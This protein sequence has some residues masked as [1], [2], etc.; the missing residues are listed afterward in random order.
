[1]QLIVIGN[2]MNMRRTTTIVFNAPYVKEEMF[3]DY[4]RSP[5][6]SSK[7]SFIRRMSTD[8]K[9]TELDPSKLSHASFWTFHVQG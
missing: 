9:S 1:M 2:Y 8:G 7:S 5:Y 3:Y 6:S 4:N